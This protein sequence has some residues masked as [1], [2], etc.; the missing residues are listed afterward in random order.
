M[1][2]GIIDIG[3]HAVRVA[4][5]SG[6]K[7]GSEEIYSYNFRS[8]I[9]DLLLKD[10]IEGDHAVY[11]V[12]NYFEQVFKNFNVE[13]VHCIATEILRNNT[14]A[15]KFVDTIYRKYKIKVRILTGEEEA[16]VGAYGL[17]SGIEDAHGVVAD[18]GGGSLE[19]TEVK[20]HEIGALKSFPL[21]MQKL[22]EDINIST[23]KIASTILHE[24]PDIKYD[25]LYFI[26]GSLRRI[27]NL[28]LQY[29]KYPLPSL[30]QF[31]IKTESMLWY[32]DKLIDMSERNYAIANPAKKGGTL[33]YTIMIARALIEVFAPE[34]IV[35]S[36]YGL[37]E[38]VRFCNL[39]EA[40]KKKNLIIER[41]KSGS[42]NIDLQNYITMFQP[43][44]LDSSLNL[45]KVIEFSLLI[46]NNA[47]LKRVSTH[48]IADYIIDL[49]VPF[50]HPQRI[51]T[52]IILCVLYNNKIDANLFS[53]SKQILHKNDYN[54]AR[55]IG[56]LM[57]LCHEIDGPFFGNLSFGVELQDNFWKLI[58]GR[59]I[60][61][62]I[63]SVA[64]NHLKSV[65]HIKSFSNL[66]I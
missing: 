13:F 62:S 2:I 39:S 25:Q 37:K 49:D 8:D 64:C 61:K 5:Y 59:S 17:I 57:R 1:N 26:G 53:A 45:N 43:F 32:M 60:P 31:R 38:G 65:I 27:T 11:S 54:N 21:G 19:I 51:M 14:N 10:N 66:E 40:E 22:K 29:I 42:E 4:V 44:L 24:F 16:R 15:Q 52:A 41:L 33:F 56:Q 28:Y 46:S 34:Y 30:H 47:T 36:T 3:T 63:F 6:D 55:I 18:F 48:N 20:N 12:F 50:S 35:I 9:E 7:L 58:I 23:E